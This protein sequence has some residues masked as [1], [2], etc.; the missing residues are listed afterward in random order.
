M[1]PSPEANPF[2]DEAPQLPTT[3]AKSQQT[4]LAPENE[5]GVGQQKGPPPLGGWTFNQQ[6]LQSGF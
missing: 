6:N 2:C 3:P 1:L 4:V 5:Q